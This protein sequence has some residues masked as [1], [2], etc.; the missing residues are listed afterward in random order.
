MPSRNVS[1]TA[2]TCQICDQPLPIG[3]PRTTCSDACRQ[4][5]WRRRHQPDTTPPPPPMA[6]PRKAVTVYECEECG[7]RALGTQ[8]CET[9]TKFMRRIGPGGIC[10]CCTEPIAY[11]EL[12]NA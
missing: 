1:V 2:G 6:R 4:A 8:Q 5:L 10:P 9:C 7:N 3:R 12:L 11:E